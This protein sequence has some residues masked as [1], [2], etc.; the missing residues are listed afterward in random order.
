MAASI[1]ANT[2]FEIAVCEYVWKSYG[3]AIKKMAGATEKTIEKHAAWLNDVEAF[4]ER[5]DIPKL[6]EI[7]ER[8]APVDS[9]QMQLS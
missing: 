3:D 7:R 8:L 4:I 2:Q 5:Y 1:K 6:G 9:G